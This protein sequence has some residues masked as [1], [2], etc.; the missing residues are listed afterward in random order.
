PA[1]LA[2]PAVTPAP[3]AQPAVAP[4]PEPAVVAP[5]PKP[6]VAPTPVA[7]TPVAP[8][9]V[10]PTPVAPT[11]EQLWRVTVNEYDAQ[12][13]PTD[14]AATVV[15]FTSFGCPTCSL[16]QDAPQKL[17]AKYGKK[18][19][20]VF[21]H[22]IIP[23]QHPDSIPASIAALAAKEQGKFWE[24]HDLLFKSNRM[25]PAAL[26]DHA[27]ALALDMAKFDKDRANPSLR[28][29]ALKDALLANEVGAHSMPNALVNGVRMKGAKDWVNLDAL[30][31]EQ[32]PKAEA[33]IKGGES[34]KTYYSKR[35]A[36]GKS[37]PQLEGVKNTFPV[38]QSPYLGPK[39]AEVT[40]TVF[41]DFECPFCSQ[42]GPKVKAFQAL[43]PNKVAFVFKHMPLTSI[44]PKAQLAS[45]AAAEAQDQ[46]KFWEYHDLLF[47]NQKALERPNLEQYAQQL[48]LDMAKF[49]EALDS[50]KH[51]ARIAADMA[52]AQRAGVTGTPAVYVAGQKYQGPRGYPPEGL[53]AVA[54]AY[55][56]MK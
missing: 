11:P 48:G 27:K 45:E 51:K 47:A 40:V 5:A 10:A 28:G 44:H 53:E 20:I 7:P 37:F 15:L 4:T 16:F 49:K 32:L 41:E 12:M 42:I 14:A 54:R 24:Y 21:K 29:Q 22:K 56:G 38:G 52:Q 36:G 31:A 30:V 33:A 19:R 8:T 18:V 17:V 35:V 43:Y 39:D 26:K 9:P 34:A 2:Q 55:G 25:D 23:A 3:V 50:G 13:G 6:V 46:G 1:P